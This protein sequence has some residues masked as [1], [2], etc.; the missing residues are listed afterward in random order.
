VKVHEKVVECDDK[1]CRGSSESRKFVLDS[2]CAF[3]N[4]S[5][6]LGTNTHFRLRWRHF[7]CPFEAKERH[8]KDYYEIP[9][10]FCERCLREKEKEFINAVHFHLWGFLRSFKR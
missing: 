9:N 6:Y 3:R 10:A 8:K 7:L 5:N 4:Y 2:R 1:K